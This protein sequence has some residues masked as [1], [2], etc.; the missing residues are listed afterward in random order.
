MMNNKDDTMNRQ[1]SVI[2]NEYYYAVISGI[3]CTIQKSCKSKKQEQQIYLI[4][5]TSFWPD[6]TAIRTIF[7]PLRKL[8]PDSAKII[9]IFPMAVYSL[10]SQNEKRKGKLND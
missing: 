7:I 1:H 9:Y 5:R 4:M 2:F 10:I 8:T 3:V 6:A